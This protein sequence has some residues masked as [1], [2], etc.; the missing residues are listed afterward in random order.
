[1]IDLLKYN[2]LTNQG[3]GILYDIIKNP[4]TSGKFRLER[5]NNPKRKGWVL[6]SMESVNNGKSYMYNGH[7]DINFI[8][9]HFSEIL[10]RDFSSILIG[11]LGLGMLPYVVKNNC[12]IIDVV[13]LNHDVINLIQPLG[14]LDNIKIYNIDVY[15]FIPD[16][17]YDVIVMD[18]WIDDSLPS[19]NDEI[20]TCLHQYM[21]F[22]NKNGIIYFP[23][24]RLKGQTVWN[25]NTNI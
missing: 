14:Y 5:Y 17:T 19:L 3:K 8:Q 10:S 20:N 25:Y 18:I 9:S 11:G 15:K 7:D 4:V 16:K 23:I 2:N 6:Y 22:L 12:N 13:E 1:M 24:N 21:P